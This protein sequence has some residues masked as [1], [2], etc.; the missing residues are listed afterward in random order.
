MSDNNYGTKTIASVYTLK[1]TRNFREQGV[2]LIRP[3]LNE[4]HCFGPKFWNQT[5]W[6]GF[7]RRLRRY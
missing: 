2:E 7:L 3:S 1:L 4:V 6:E 5:Q